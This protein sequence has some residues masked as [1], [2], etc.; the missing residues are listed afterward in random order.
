MEL[1]ESSALEIATEV[2][3]S[4]IIQKEIQQIF[5]ICPI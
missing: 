1:A 4:N 2:Y 3:A 5:D